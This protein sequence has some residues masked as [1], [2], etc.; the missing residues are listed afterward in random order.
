ME[1]QHPNRRQELQLLGAVLSAYGCGGYVE[2]GDEEASVIVFYTKKPPDSEHIV[3]QPGLVLPFSSEVLKS[4][5]ELHETGSGARNLWTCKKEG[6]GRLYAQCTRAGTA[7]KSRCIGKRARLS[8]KI[9]C[10]ATVTAVQLT[11]K[12]D[13]LLQKRIIEETKKMQYDEND[14]KEA[15]LSNL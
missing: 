3:L 12:F 14:R 11:K 13:C 2:V 8:L 9:G 5:C 15:A 1:I 4:L 10:R 7:R 6:Y